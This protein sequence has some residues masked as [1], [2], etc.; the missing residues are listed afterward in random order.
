MC[1]LIGL[2]S[3][4]LKDFF[5]LKM[6]VVANTK[7]L[8]IKVEKRFGNPSYKTPVITFL[9]VSQPELNDLFDLVPS[10]NAAEVLISD[11]QEPGELYN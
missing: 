2:Q 5:S 6:W 1:T 3:W 7:K 4:F 8:L 9:T 10:K 11:L